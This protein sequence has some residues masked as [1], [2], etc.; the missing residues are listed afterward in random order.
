MQI[1]MVLPCGHTFCGIC[2][3]SVVVS[4]L[5]PSK[6]LFFLFLFLFLF[7]LSSLSFFSLLSL[8]FSLSFS[9]FSSLNKGDANTNGIA[10]WSYF[11]WYLC[12]F[13]CC[14]FFKAIKGL[15]F[16]SFLFLFL[17][18]FLSLFS[19]FSLFL[20]LCFHPQTRRCKY[21]WYCLV[22]FLFFSSLSLSLFSLFLSLFSSPNKGD[23]NT[24][25]ISLLLL[26]LSLLSDHQRFFFLFLCLSLSF[27]VF[28]CLSL[29]FSVFLCLLFV[30]LFVFIP[31]QGGGNT[32]GIA[33]WSYFLWY[34]CYFCLLFLL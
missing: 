2:A 24:N 15:L 11:L 17:F 6:V 9:L 8:S 30:S 28:L 12:Y 25:G 26:L 29:S 1:P 3:T 21:Q 7:L 16:F 23:V 27:S 20:S 32:N 31:K 5:R 22:S 33:L 18:L 10:L 34:L 4:S 14:F 13:C 19:L